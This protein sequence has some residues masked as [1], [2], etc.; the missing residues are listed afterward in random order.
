MSYGHGMIF[1]FTPKR[2]HLNEKLD[3]CQNNYTSCHDFQAQ[4]PKRYA[5]APTVDLLRLKILRATKTA[6]LTP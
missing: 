3:N 4:Y 5:K 6:F 2:H 1:F